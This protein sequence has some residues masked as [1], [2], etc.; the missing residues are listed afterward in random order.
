MN[1]TVLP[2]LLAFSTVLALS[3][4]L[5]ASSAN[6]Q[7]GKVTRLMTKDLPDVPG[8]ERWWKPSTSLPARSPSHIGE[9]CR[10]DAA[11]R[12]DSQD[13]RRYLEDHLL[14]QAR[15]LRASS[16]RVLSDGCVGPDAFIQRK[17]FSPPGANQESVSRLVRRDR[18]FLSSQS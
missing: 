4:V 7:V 3:S 12:R 18:V 13:R 8:K 2:L 15:L 11:V 10:S 16:N 6:L 5:A 1:K 14:D 17:T 9:R